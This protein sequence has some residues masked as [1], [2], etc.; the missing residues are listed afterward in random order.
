M[1]LRDRVALITEARFS[2][3]MR[4]LPLPVSVDPTAIAQAAKKEER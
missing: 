2:K 4:R 1:R 3:E